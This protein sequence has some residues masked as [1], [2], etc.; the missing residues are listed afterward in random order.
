MSDK[1]N[2]KSTHSEE[3]IKELEKKRDE[4]L[5]GW[6]RAK[7]DYVNLKRESEQKKDE[8]IKFANAAVLADMI[9]MYDNFKKAF[10]HNPKEKENADIKEWEN[11]CEGIGHIKKQ[12][13]DFLQKFGIEE[14]KTIGEKFDPT[15]HES[16]GE[17][18]AEGKEPGIIIK[19]VQSGYTLHG[20]VVNP[21][22]VI[23]VK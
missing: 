14:I 6:Q 7:A 20:K 23:I 12:M 10:E 11:W 8:W 19:E 4:Y 16:V 3:K 13:F 22:K 15:L 18:E 9:P 5:A 1:K 2:K 21:A 17:E